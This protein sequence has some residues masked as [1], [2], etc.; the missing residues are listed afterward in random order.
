M[1]DR[2]N[3]YIYTTVKGPGTKSG[4]YT[5]LLEY[6][7]EK[8]PATLT[9]QGTL[10]DATE[11]RAHLRVLR[12]ALERLRKPCE[13][14][15]YTDSGYLKQGAEVWLRG[16]ISAGWLNAKGKPV[17]NREEWEQV[18][19]LLEKHLA[20]FQ[21]GANHSYRNW[22]QTETEKKEKERRQCLNDS[23]NLTVQ[24]K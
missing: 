15:I 10:E 5:Y 6:V 20:T 22:I 12:E 7:T 1:M 19:E 18:A 9:K 23:E 2:V 11:N 24:R 3:L 16:W 13:I 21:V 14:E 17:A 8:G 4:T